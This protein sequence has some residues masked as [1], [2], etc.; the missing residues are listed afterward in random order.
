MPS[1]C[2]ASQSIQSSPPTLS[3]A[4][5]DTRVLS[6]SRGRWCAREPPLQAS[7]N[8][9]RSGRCRGWQTSDEEPAAPA[10]NTSHLG[11]GRLRW[12]RLPS[13]HRRG[14]AGKALHQ[15]ETRE[16]SERVGAWA[17]RGGHRRRCSKER[18]IHSWWSHRHRFGWNNTKHLRDDLPRHKAASNLKK[19]QVWLMINVWFMQ[20]HSLLRISSRGYT[21][22]VQFLSSGAGGSVYWFPIKTLHLPLLLQRAAVVCWARIWPGRDAGWSSAAVWVWQPQAKL[23][24]PPDHLLQVW[25]SFWHSL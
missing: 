3:L 22:F 11:R 12:S 24:P 8:E 4:F 6:G 21:R 16:E 15:R 17:R 14:P 1:H 25:S 9:A 23:T 5:Y 2:R 19:A 10:G 13:P 18:F 7:S 20:M